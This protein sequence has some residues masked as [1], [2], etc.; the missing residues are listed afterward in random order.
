MIARKNPDTINK[1]LTSQQLIDQA[2]K[3]L[4]RLIRFKQHGMPNKHAVQLTT[5]REYAFSTFT[6]TDPYTS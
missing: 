1:F 2:Y 4:L 6:K 3:K 5:S